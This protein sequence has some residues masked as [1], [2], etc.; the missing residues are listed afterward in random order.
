MS[1]AAEWRY[2][3]SP[4]LRWWPSVNAQTVRADAIAGLI[5]AILVIPQGVAFATLAGMPPE[6]GLYLSMVPAV[7]AALWG[8]SWH[9]VSGPTTAISLLVFA[10]LSPLA[11]PGSAEYIRLAL[12]LSFLS[13]AILLALGVARLGGLANFISGTVVVGFTAGAGLLIAASQLGNFFGLDLPRT[14]SLLQGVHALLLHV[15][16]TKAPVLA[17]SMVTLGV[18]VASRRWWRKLPYMIVALVAGS[19]FAIVLSAMLGSERAALAVIGKVPA[20]LPPLS[21]PALSFDALRSL[22]GAAVSI[23]LLS[24]AQAI[25]IARAIA[26]RSGQRIDANQELIGQGLSNLAA[27]FFSGY[28]SSASLNRTGA[29][30]EAGARTPLAAVLSVPFLVALLFAI[31]P[32]IAFIPAAVVAAILVLVGWGL[33]DFAAIRKIARMSRPEVFVLAVTFLATMT[34]NLEVAILVGVFLSLV[35]YLYRTSRPSMR[36]LVPD[37][38]DPERRMVEVHGSLRECPQLK[39]VRIEGSIYFGAINHVATHFDTLRKVSPAQKHLLLMVK[40]MNFVDVA[41]A[42]LLAEEAAARRAQG[43]DLYLYSPRQPAREMLQRG[44]QLDQ[45]GRDHVFASAD[46]AIAKVFPRLDPNVCRRC[47]A[48]IFVECATVPAADGPQ[49]APDAV[50]GDLAESG[51]AGDGERQ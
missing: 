41:G 12:T 7:V 48:R 30:F 9:A 20:P 19:A 35:A 32:L 21:M 5:G 28:P 47:T 2:R 1:L 46:E 10:T 39:I 27:A 16:E 6:Y 24:I 26:T 23:A 43:G 33:I 4:F 49:H 34:L 8:S 29:N 15:S 38:A 44:G 18:A 51:R 31:A 40:S 50:R 11:T 36:T 3:L 37:P 22:T 13:G 45:I 25:P 14:D 42:D 17:V